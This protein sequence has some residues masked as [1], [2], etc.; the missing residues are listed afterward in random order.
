MDTNFFAGMTLEDAVVIEEHYIERQARRRRLGYST[1]EQEFELAGLQRQLIAQF[2][3][4]YDVP[5][6]APRE[7]TR[8]EAQ[9]ERIGAAI[10]EMF[11][12]RHGGEFDPSSDSMANT[13]TMQVADRAWAI[14]QEPE[15]PSQ[16]LLVQLLSDINARMTGGDWTTLDEVCAT[17][18]PVRM[19]GSETMT[20]LRALYVVR[21]RLPAYGDFLARSKAAFKRRGRPDSVFRG[22]DE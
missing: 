16:A 7:L 5:P 14:A 19:S 21:D 4:Q 8:E 17:R 12:T 18:D 6:Y 22:L 2:P 13:M 20:Y 11:H 15:A 1:P 3:E 10:W 9:I